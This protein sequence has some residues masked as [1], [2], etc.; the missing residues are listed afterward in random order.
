MARRRRK[1]SA[2]KLVGLA[3]SGMPAPIR[4]VASSRL[5]S[6]VLMIGIPVLLALGILQ[7]SW[8][9][10]RPTLSV[11]R[12]RAQEV[13][14]E[15]REQVNKETD[16]LIDKWSDEWRGDEREQMIDRARDFG[17]KITNGLQEGAGPEGSPQPWRPGILN[18]ENQSG[19]TGT[20]GNRFLNL[21]QPQFNSPSL[22]QP[23]QQPSGYP[24]PNYPQPGYQAPGYQPPAYSPP[25]YTQP[26]APQPGSQY[27]SATTGRPG[28]Y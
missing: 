24:Q 19:Q 17:Q 5:G 10:W 7:V 2:Q 1:N 6:F 13:G 28:R 9:G 27:P 23:G 3:T 8:N 4:N 12:E 20:S 11:N 25:G 26:A 18:P 21:P 14:D 22:P 15:V 16:G